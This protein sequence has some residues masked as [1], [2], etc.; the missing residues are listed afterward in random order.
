MTSVGVSSDNVFAEAGSGSVA[1]NAAERGFARLSVP[2]HNVQSQ[3]G[4]A[5]LRSAVIARQME[6]GGGGNDADP[7]ASLN[8]QTL[9][10]KACDPTLASVIIL[11]IRKLSAYHDPPTC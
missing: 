3:S 6:C 9:V 11:P 5:A 8:S 2:S 1:S 10:W 4:G 7:L